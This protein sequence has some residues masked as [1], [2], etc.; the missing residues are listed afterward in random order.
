MVVIYRLNAHEVCHTEELRK[1]ALRGDEGAIREALVDEG[2]AERIDSAEPAHTVLTA[3]ASD[4]GADVQVNTYDQCLL[5]DVASSGSWYLVHNQAMSE[6][7]VSQ[8]AEAI[9]KFNPLASHLVKHMHNRMCVFGTAFLVKLVVDVGGKE[10]QPEYMDATMCEVGEIVRKA[11]VVRVFHKQD[12]VRMHDRDVLLQL[13]VSKVERVVDEEAQLA[14]L[15]S[16]GLVYQFGVPPAEAEGYG[17]Q[18]E[19]IDNHHVV[20]IDTSKMGRILR[21]VGQ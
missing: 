3:F 2:I 5:V 21:F 11:F 19:S 9:A 10:S 17:I 20:D 6:R 15:P 16:H 8:D 18:L 13:D 1:M 12:G 7:A 4:I 14:Y